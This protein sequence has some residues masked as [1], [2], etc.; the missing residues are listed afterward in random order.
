MKVLPVVLILLIFVFAGTVAAQQTVYLPLI[1][2]GAAV[3]A[4]AT[5]TVL[6][7]ATVPN[8]QAT[9]DALLFALTVQAY[10]ATPTPTATSTPVPT[11]TP[12]PTDTAT[13]TETATPNALATQLADLK[14]AVA[15][16]SAATPQGPPPTANATIIALEQTVTALVPT[17]TPTATSTPTPTAT[18]TA[19]A[20]ATPTAT[21]DL[22]AT[23]AALQATL[24]AMQT[25]GGTI[26]QGGK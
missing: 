18:A 21:P 25:P 3:T 20:T 14:T 4:T 12:T 17:V 2:D 10:T 22:L 11:V 16:L 19:T 7:T 1:G 24:E 5:A 26:P 23:V 9:I 15:T 8:I 6:P 13:A